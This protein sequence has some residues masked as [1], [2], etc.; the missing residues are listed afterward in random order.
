MTPTDT[1]DGTKTDVVLA[2]SMSLLWL[3]PVVEVA[4]EK[5]TTQLSNVNHFHAKG[6]WR[7]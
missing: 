4:V 6:Q 1:T 3:G 2:L 7:I 5:Q